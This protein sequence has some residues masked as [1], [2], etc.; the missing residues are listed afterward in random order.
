MIVS[1]AHALAG[2]AILAVLS[3]ATRR[4]AEVVDLPDM[5]DAHG[6]A[7]AFAGVFEGRLLVAGGANFPDDVM[8]WEGGRKVWHDRVFALGLDANAGE[9]SEV[10]RL[11]AP[12][13]YGV[14]LTTPDGVLVIGGGDAN[15]HFADVW[16]MRPQGGRVVFRGLPSL[17]RPVAQMTGALVGR[18]AHVMGGIEDP[19]ATEASAA[20]WVL[21]L[22]N[23]AAG[24]RTLPPL[25]A[26][27]RILAIATATADALLVFGGC[28]LA[29]DSTGSVRRTYLRDAWRFSGGRWTRLADM[30]HPLAAA[31]SPAPIDGQGVFVVSGDDGTQANARP[32]DHQGFT[33]E[34]LRYDMSANAWQ[35]VGMLDAP[36]P[37]TLPTAPWRDGFVFVNGELRP[38]VR[39]RAVFLFRPRRVQ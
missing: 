9:W 29:P 20:H 7:G 24:W 3:C 26:A 28:S 11:P 12:N 35:S 39:T 13:A 34:V 10:G 16:M 32:A 15:R 33:R 5:P 27:G 14:S 17:P 8:P 25:P 2:T 18:A 6:F 31:A 4:P 22:D 19:R 38:G 36:A 1:V 37:V 30:P 23:T 21:D